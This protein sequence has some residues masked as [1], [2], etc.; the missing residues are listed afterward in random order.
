MNPSDSNARRTLAI[1]LGAT[2][3]LIVI[4]TI[5]FLLFESQ[6]KTIAGEVINTSQATYATAFILMLLLASDIFL[7][8]PSSLLSTAS[9]ALFG[10]LPGTFWSW[11]GMNVGCAIAYAVGI[12]LGAPVLRRFSGAESMVRAQ[13]LIRRYGYWGLVLARPV[14]VLA[15]TTA[16]IAGMGRMPLRLFVPAATLSNLGISFAYSTAGAILP[17][18]AVF[19]VFVGAVSLPV[20]VWTVGMVTS[21]RKLPSDSLS[22]RGQ[23]HR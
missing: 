19:W 20:L 21:R 11:L 18:I 5:G 8:V 12:K 23:R 2:S 14:P 22:Q 7:P 3:L 4:I 1:W 13:E 6:M 9:G 16:I 15:E 17:T 10:I